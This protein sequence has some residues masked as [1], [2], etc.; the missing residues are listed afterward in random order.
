MDTNI[1]EMFLRYQSSLAETVQDLQIHATSAGSRDEV[2]RSAAAALH[3]NVDDFAKITPV[4]NTLRI[5][6]DALDAEGRAYVSSKFKKGSAPDVSVLASFEARRKTIVQAAVA[7][8]R[9][10]M[11]TSGWAALSVYITDE[12]SK[13]IQKGQPR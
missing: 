10:N 12:F 6:L 3:I 5:T 7:Q 1:F 2:A 9:S 4:Y 11:S 8:L 13:N